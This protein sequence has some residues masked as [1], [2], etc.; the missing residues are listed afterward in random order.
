MGTAIEDRHENISVILCSQLSSNGAQKR[1]CMLE[2]HKMMFVGPLSHSALYALRVDGSFSSG[3]INKIK[4]LKSRAICV[5]SSLSRPS[6]A[7]YSRAK[8][9][10]SLPL[11][12]SSPSLR[13]WRT[14][15]SPFVDRLSGGFVGPTGRSPLSPPLLLQH[16]VPLLSPPPRAA[17]ATAQAK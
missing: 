16:H 17:V 4:K 9:P 13:L 2:A 5:G 3:A 8:C 10:S 12:A 14:T 6:R 1:I 11:S 15:H 7:K